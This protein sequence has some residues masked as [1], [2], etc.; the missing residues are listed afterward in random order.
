VRRPSKIVNVGLIGCGQLAQS[1][2]LKVLHN[3]PEVRL[4]VIAEPDTTLRKAASRLAP[5]AQAVSTYQQLL[6]HDDLQAVVLAL[7]S[8]RHAEAA[9]AAFRGG[10][11][12]YL[13]KPLATNRPD[14]EAV[15]RAWEQTKCVGMIGFNYRFNKLYR[16]ARDLIRGGAVGEVIAVRSVFALAARPMAAWKT[17]RATGGGVLL[18]LASHH[19]DLVRFLIDTDIVDVRCDLESRV[20][21]GDSAFVQLRLANGATAQLFFSSCASDEDQFD[22]YGTAGKLAIDRCHAMDV[23]RHGPR[24]GTYRADQFRNGL[25]SLQRVGYGLE[26]RRALGH[27]PSWQL[28]LEHFVSAVRGECPAEP[29]LYEGYES[30]KIVMAAEEAAMSSR[31]QPV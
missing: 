9:I 6:A 18:D 28:A 25:R 17:R 15:L 23:Q 14:A 7:P 13:E 26:R 21:E 8:D 22:I 20:S 2:H 16:R 1:V 30:L 29:D 31:L 5:H 19:F 24:S 12:V 11:H 3:M 10:K 4:T 27:E